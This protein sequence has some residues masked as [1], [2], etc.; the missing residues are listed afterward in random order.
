MQGNYID[1]LA[2]FDK[3]LFEALAPKGATME[4]VAFTG[5][6]KGD[7]VHIRFVKPF[8]ANWISDIT[9]NGINNNEAYFIDQGRVVPFG[10]IYWQHKHIIKNL[11]PT[12][13]QIID[14]ISFKGVNFIWTL[15]LYPALFIGFYPRKKIYKKYFG[16]IS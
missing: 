4:I 16:S 10:I 12:T 15:L 9:D 7:M 6:K 14:D 1:V 5:S 13:C 2:K 8:K 3:K 11:S